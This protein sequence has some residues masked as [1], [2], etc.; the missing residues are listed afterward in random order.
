MLKNSS[1]SKSPSL[2]TCKFIHL[3][4]I[5]RLPSDIVSLVKLATEVPS[6]ARCLLL[7]ILFFC[8]LFFL[9]VSVVCLVR[10]SNR[11]EIMVLPN[12]AF[13]GNKDDPKKQKPPMTDF[14][15]E[16]PI[17]TKD[18]PAFITDDGK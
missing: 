3:Q 15:A 5:D 4:G 11:Q 10:S 18:N 7:Y 1:I 6:V 9:L 16:K 12:S 8:G 2:I 13:Y 17:D 14:T